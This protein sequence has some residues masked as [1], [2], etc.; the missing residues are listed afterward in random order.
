LNLV[1]NALKFTEQG[2]IV[3]NVAIDSVSEEHLS[4]HFSIRDTGV[5][6][7]REKQSSIFESFTQADGSMSRKYGGTGLG[8]TISNRL[9]N[10]MGGK[11]W[12]ESEPGRAALS[13]SPH[14]SRSRTRTSR[15]PNQR[16][17]SAGPTCPSWLW[18]TTKR[19]AAS[20]TRCS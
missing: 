4:L 10:M 9:V 6:I 20:F 1:G 11:I 14:R 16:L 3:V 5:G 12:V 17:M 8:L 7:P 15:T 19:I 13:I 2:E 18:T